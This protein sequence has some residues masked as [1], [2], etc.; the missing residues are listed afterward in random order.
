M[1]AADG[2]TG[3]AYICFAS[4]RGADWEAVCLDRDIAVQG[5]SFEEVETSLCQAI[6]LYL[7]AAHQESPSVRDALLGR[8][9]P[10]W[11]YARYLVSFARFAIRHA[12]R[13]GTNKD[14]KV[15]TGF[16][17]PCRG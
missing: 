15:E 2:P 5:R 14:G 17:A 10:L 12:L 1:N 13:R 4:G 6:A 11:V 3:H 9:A 7:E 16:V 8:R